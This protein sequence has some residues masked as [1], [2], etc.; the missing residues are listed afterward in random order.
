MFSSSF[1]YFPIS[2]SLQCCLTL[3]VSFGHF[4][5]RIKTDT[6][7]QVCKHR[8]L[9]NEASPHLSAH[10]SCNHKTWQA[11][12]DPPKNLSV[13]IVN[14]EICV[15]TWIY[16]H[17]LYQWQITRLEADHF[18]LG[19]WSNFIVSY[20][21]EESTVWQAK[22]LDITDLLSK[23]FLRAT[24]TLSF[25]YLI[26]LFSPFQYYYFLQE[27]QERPKG[28]ALILFIYYQTLPLC[29]SAYA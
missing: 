28:N 20:F 12:N 29:S 2:S 4:Q 7:F 5:V 27:W 22:V 9:L 3:L 18:A 10:I 13:N 11:W 23:A 8:C 15:C 16:V 21:S 26:L 25:H 1:L 6:S 19:Y 17:I 14:E 24:A